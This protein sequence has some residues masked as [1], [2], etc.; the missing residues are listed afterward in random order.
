MKTLRERHEGHAMIVQKTAQ[1]VI[2]A[3]PLADRQQRTKILLEALFK[4][5]ATI[6]SSFIRAKI[7]SRYFSPPVNSHKIGMV[8][9]GLID[10]I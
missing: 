4:I 10:E 2:R 8:L 9:Y 1:E 3:N 7:S 6:T 5:D